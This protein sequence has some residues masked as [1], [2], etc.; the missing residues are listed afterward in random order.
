MNSVV[1]IPARLHSTRL[2]RK[3][4]L[5][6]TGKP[7]LQ[8]PFESA[9]KAKRPSSVLIV[10]DSEELAITARGFG[11]KVEMT[12]PSC[13]SGTDRVAEVARRWDEAD[14]FVNVQG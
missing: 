12:S 4:L 6:E 8:H 10:V 1:V 3:M 2:P 5:A 13:V 14:V 11:A 7:V 9:S